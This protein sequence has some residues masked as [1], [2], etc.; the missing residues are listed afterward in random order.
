MEQMYPFLFT[1]PSC[2]EKLNTFMKAISL[3]L[4]IHELQSQ[5]GEK[6]HLKEVTL[7]TLT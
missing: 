5:E 6:A 7:P 1:K 3:A 2:Q 4:E